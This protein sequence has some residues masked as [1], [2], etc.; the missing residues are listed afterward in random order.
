MDDID[1]EVVAAYYAERAEDA[2]DRGNLV[3]HV[4]WGRLYHSLVTS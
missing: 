3:V 2:L 1:W 4:K